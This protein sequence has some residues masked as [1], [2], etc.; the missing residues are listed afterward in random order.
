ME[1]IPLNRL[2]AERFEIEQIILATRGEQA[3]ADVVE[4]DEIDARD[5]F[6]GS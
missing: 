4:G 2:I 5:T 1:D 6:P 3:E